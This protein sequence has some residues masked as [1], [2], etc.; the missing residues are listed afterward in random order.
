MPR[1][2]VTPGARWGARL[3]ALLLSA[4]VLSCAALAAPSAAGVPA[5]VGPSTGGPVGASTTAPGGSGLD[6]VRPDQPG[7]GAIGRRSGPVVLVGVPGLLWEDVTSENTP[8]L[9]RMAEEGSIGNVSIRTATSRTCPTDGWLS[10]SAGQRA[11]SIRE[12]FTVCEAAPEPERDGS[13][14]VV[15]GFGSYVRQNARSPFGAPVGLLGQT[16][17]DAG[18]TTLAVGHGAALGVAD[19]SGRVDHYVDGV[20]GL[21]TERLEGVSLAAVE[22][23]EL[24]R[25]Y[26][27]YPDPLT[28]GREDDGEKDGAEA[29]VDGEKDGEED[30]EPPEPDPDDVPEWERDKALSTL[31]GRLRALENVLPPGS[32]LMVVGV[33]MDT[34]PSQLT[35]ALSGEIT[36]EGFTG[37]ESFLA[38][39]STRRAGL[40]VLTDITPT[41]LTSL[42]MRATE[43]TSGRPWHLAG[44]PPTTDKA[45]GRLVEFNTAAIVV[46]AAIP[47]FF[48]GLVAFQLLI[49][50]AAAC[51]LHRYSNRQRGKRA[52][53]LSLTRIVALAGAAFPV[54][55]Y[56]ANLVPWWTSSIP[57]LAL[58]ACVLSADALVVALA[59]AGPWRRTVLG[60]MT[61]VAGATT[62]VLFLDLC[63]GADLQMN[64]PTG[65]SPIVAGRFY[66][67]GNIAFATFAT[68]MLMA[69]AGISH[70]LISRGRRG[71]A[72]VTTLVIG[73]AT[74]LIV[75]WPGL[76]TDF[77]GVIALFPGLAVTTMMIA[78]IRVTLPRLA[79]VS[80]AAV[81]AIALLAWLD[82]LRPPQARSHFGAFAGQV[83]NGEAAAVVSRK[84]SAMLGTL[85][86]WQ[87]TLLA[88]CA[89]VFLFVV[90]QRPIHWRFGALQ[91]AYEY[92]PTLRAGLTGSLLTALVGFAVNDS[93]VAIPAIALTVAVP[94]TL[95]ACVWALQQQNG[96]RTPDP[97]PAENAQRM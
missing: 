93:G 82:Y 40:V 70:E 83:V 10:V 27:V 84:L 63:F 23:A 51:A 43:P 90:L 4:A 24:T 19:R 66:G 57:P 64:S 11:L 69:V 5:T 53:V 72:V 42:G 13:G 80:A 37:A 38:S 25:L 18:G 8:T 81:S 47:G 58:L 52:R 86:N 87:L 94:L 6:V 20:H 22:L 21:T 39:E 14:A 16:V 15:P 55:S 34:G 26:P 61:V 41:L 56:L 62:G 49:Y 3:C 59:M 77:G 74:V 31:D 48:S 73:S 91:G 71:A 28:P 36:E 50:A 95:S 9:W 89:L 75:G 67:I 88:A 29:P 92:A 7:P 96:D 60:P 65:Y 12:R 33:S 1:R 79:V 97:E 32:S 44:R 45:V 54:A 30:E 17:R 35:V 2:L 85:G 76:G 78:G 68:G 46:G